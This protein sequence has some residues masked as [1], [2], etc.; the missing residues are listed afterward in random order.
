MDDNHISEIHEMLDVLAEA[1][2]NRT[3]VGK[4]GERVEKVEADHTGID[5]L[6]QRV[7]TLED[8]LDAVGRLLLLHLE[9]EH[10]IVVR[11]GEGDT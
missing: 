4:L 8:A 2:A 9:R 10:G 6:R 7:A 11:N 3:E 5:E 1:K